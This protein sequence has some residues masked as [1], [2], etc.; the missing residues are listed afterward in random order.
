MP[1]TSDRYADLQSNTWG[2]SD[3]L[4]F[5]HRDFRTFPSIL[6]FDI[7]IKIQTMLPKVHVLY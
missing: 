2:M 3:Y 7:K 5:I 6:L 4:Q 1:T